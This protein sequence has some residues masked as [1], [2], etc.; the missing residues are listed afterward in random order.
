MKISFIVPIYNVEKYLRQCLDS[1]I[2][3]TYQN[4]EIIAVNDGAT[5]A[6]PKILKEY[7]SID[8]RIRILNQKNQGLSMARNTGLENV[9]G[10]YVLFVDSDDY[11][12]LNMAQRIAETIAH[13]PRLDIITFSRTMF[14]SDITKMVD[15]LYLSLENCIYGDEF[16]KIA[17]NEQKLVAAVWQKAFSYSFL[18]RHRI[19]FIPHILYEDF[20]FTVHS[21]VCAKQVISIPDILYFYRRN[22]MQSITNKISPHDTDVL[23]TLEYL[24]KVLID[25]KHEDILET[26]IWQIYTFK[27][28]A[29]ATFFKYPK[30]AFWNITGWK[31]CRKIRSHPIIQLYLKTTAQLAPNRNLRIAA[32]LIK[33]NLPSFYVV[34]KISK[35]IFPNHNF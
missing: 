8:G 15:D 4:I 20:S 9:T 13:H 26:N 18:Q 27:W 17:M 35:I 30:I 32:T 24:Q 19:R 6:S 34:R 21:F 5:D 22:N 33:W 16:L 7:A 28:C 11:V 29:N 2:N 1:L 12:S 14:Y 3:Q 25:T 10:E 31:N 23:K